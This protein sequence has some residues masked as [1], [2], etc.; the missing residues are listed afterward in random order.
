MES[1]RK[2]EAIAP[3][4]VAARLGGHWLSSNPDYLLRADMFFRI[5]AGLAPPD[6]AGALR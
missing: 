4:L 3:K 2:V 5:A 6:A 1:F